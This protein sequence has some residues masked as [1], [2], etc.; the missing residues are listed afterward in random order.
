MDDVRLQASSAKF[1]PSPELNMF[2]FRYIAIVCVFASCLGATSVRAQDETTRRS[3]LGVRQKLVERKMIELESKLQVIAEKLKE[4]EPER[5]ARLIAA[6]QASKEKLITREMAEIT[7]LLDQNKLSPAKEKLDTV[8]A[9]L[10]SLFRLLTNEKDQ[11]ISKQDEIKMLEKI[12]N[13]IQEQIKDQRKQE[14][15]AKKVANKEEAVKNLEAQIKQL[16]SLIDKQRGV[17]K[18]TED[19][20]GNG[21]RELDKV[22]DKQFEVRQGTEALK[23]EIGGKPGQSKPNDGKPGDGKP[24][25]DKPGDDKPG[26]DKPGDDKPGDDKPGD[27]KP[28]DDKPSDD[29]PSDDKPSDDKPSDGK[30]SDGKPSDGKPS[31]GKPSDGKPSDGKP[32][33]GK[34]SDGKPS[35]GKPSDGKPSD[36]KPSDG[37]PSDGQSG[38]SQSQ[39][40]Q[41][42]QE[43]LEK[44]TEHQQRA[45]EKLGSGKAD[46]AKEQEQKAVDEMEK[47]LSD[48]EKEK[49]RIESLPPEALEQMAQEQ[50]RTRDKNLDILEELKK[51]PKPKSENGEPSSGQPPGQQAMEQAG[52]S[53][54]EA[55][56]E[57]QE[58]DPEEAAK[59]QQQAAKK[60]EEAIDEIEERLNQ[61]REETR[62]EKLARLEGRFREMLERQQIASVITVELN[63]KRANLSELRRRDQLLLLQMANEEM[64]INEIAQQAYDLLL[65]DG[66]SIVF[67]EIIQELRDDL[68]KAAGLL[69]EE[70]T[71]RFT[72]LIQKEIETTI[73]DLIDALKEAQEKKDDDS[74]GGGG[75]GGGGGDQPL[76][77]MS[78]ELKILKM[79]QLRLN[80][81]TRKVEQMR[82]DVELGPKLDAEALD[83]ADLQLKLL[84]MTEGIMEKANE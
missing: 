18:D 56:D 51:A 3:E 10:E 71:D 22:A 12:K 38:D 20:A 17:I 8:I 44:A 83:A 72:Q 59:N 70:R 23:D 19:N 78:A 55:A 13:D 34:P 31:D 73:E 33:D 39:P 50:R 25:D 1:P 28:S 79:Q 82:G 80:R 9:N 40:P 64:E 26:D 81:R 32:S 75:G 67:P 14:D 47:A 5:A 42:G 4:T 29:K 69:Q 57:L 62:E 84:Q 66:T 48:L 35:D 15:E 45:E 58:Q 74:S 61:L 6:Y 7:V 53:M 27:G 65:E 43:A 54:Q 76:L 60:M 68:A 11:E 30:P 37:K 16:K 36:G 24:G 21:L 63:D 46:E 49:R 77:K 2:I 41:P 52:D